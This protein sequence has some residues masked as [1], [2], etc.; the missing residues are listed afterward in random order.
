VSFA[1]ELAI[2]KDLTLIGG[3]NGCDSGSS[4]RTTIDGSS[5]SGTTLVEVTIGSVVLKELRIVDGS[6]TFSGGGI[7]VFNG[8][9]VLLDHVDVLGN[10]ASYGGGVY[11][12]STAVVTATNNSWIASNTATHTGGGV[13]VFG[14][15]TALEESDI[16]DNIAADG[17]GIGADSA[18]VTLN[19][20]SVRYN[21]ATDADGMGGGIYAINGST[22]DIT[23]NS[24]VSKNSAFDGAGVYAD[25]SAVNVGFGFFSANSASNFGGGFH[26]TNGASLLGSSM[27]I[28]GESTTLSNSASRGAGTYA[29]TSTVTI[30][31][32]QVYANVAAD[33]GAGF[34]ADNSTLNL[35]SV[36]VGKPTG[37]RPNKLGIDGHEGVGLYLT[38]TTT[39]TLN[40]TTVSGNVFQTT[41]LTFG[42]GIYIT[43][44]STLLLEN[45]S[46]V[47]HH[48]A[49]S[50]ASGRG[51][52]IYASAS[53]VTISNSQVVSNTAG[54]NGGAIRVINGCTLNIQNDSVISYNEA[55]NEEGG[56]VASSGDN[57]INISNATFQH[58]Q[59]FTDGGAIY[60]DNGTLDFSGWWDLRSNSAGGD[61]GG[62]AVEGSGDVDFLVTSGL[63][64]SYLALNTAGGDGGGVFIGNGDTVEINV[65]V[66]Y[67]LLFN[68][69]DAARNVGAFYLDNVALLQL[70]GVGPAFAE[71]KVNDADRGGGIYA[72]GNSYVACYGTIFGADTSGNYAEDTDGGAIYLEASTL[73]SAD[74]IYRNNEAPRHGG[75]IA[76]YTSS[77]TI[78]TDFLLCDPLTETCSSFSGNNADSDNNSI[79]TG[80]AVYIDGGDLTIDHT[81]IY[82]NTAYRGGAIYQEGATTGIVRNSLFYRNSASVNGSAVHV[83]DGDF[84]LVHATLANNTGGYVFHTASTGTINVV[85]SI[86]WGNGS[87]FAGV[88]FAITLCNID[89][90][91]EVGAVSDPLFVDSGAGGDYHLSP[92]SP[93]VNA[94]G[95]GLAYDLD[96]IARPIGPLFDMGAFE[97]YRFLYLPLILR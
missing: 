80:G 19:D 69:N 55:Q 86:A 16:E 90:A 42:G 41:G 25:S 4:T 29:L 35:T 81:A 85:N 27:R 43:K 77:I 9:D 87:G 44:S 22:V 30:T 24:V 88:S 32:S 23:N 97:F 37:D 72:A 48:L 46:F 59:A 50:T 94:C 33:K 89:Q 2:A 67:N 57:D 52:G 73:D 12:R 95:A 63:K 96:G 18:N 38:D 6:G 68:T 15:F 74:C 45:N 31:G 36:T 84:D 20:S 13:R 93:A 26:L 28:G 70:M 76:A 39:A 40:D 53:T 11:V 62:I 82:S 34:Y 64:P 54:T 79:G 21:Q 51:A 7:D 14:T 10:N 49:P 17:G 83:F 1:E 78:D 61:G 66:P 47:E 92:G 56:A 91:G 71:I 60:I 5:L 8:A 65:H 3:Y 58:N 75:A